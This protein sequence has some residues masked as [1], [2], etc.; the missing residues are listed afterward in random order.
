MYGEIQLYINKFIFDF[1]GYKLVYIKKFAGLINTF[2]HITFFFLCFRFFNSISYSFVLTII[3][4]LLENYNDPNYFDS[5]NS[6]LVLFFT[7]FSYLI[8]DLFYNSGK[9]IY[10]V[11]LAFIIFLMTIT[12]VNYGIYMLFGYFLVLIAKNFNI[13]EIKKI[14]ILLLNNELR[15]YFASFIVIFGIYFYY[16]FSLNSLSDWLKN[17]LV[18]P[19]Y[20]AS[21]SRGL[22]G[23]FLELFPIPF[24]ARHNPLYN[25]IYF[26]AAFSYFIYLLKYLHIYIKN[27]KINDTHKKFFLYSI[28]AFF[29][30]LN[31]NPIIDTWHF[32]WS[33]PL[34]LIFNFKLI[35]DLTSIF[36]RNKVQIIS[37]LVLLIYFFPALYWLSHRTITNKISQEYIIADK[38]DFIAGMKLKNYEIEFFEMI[39]S[40]FSIK[41]I[42]DNE[43]IVDLTRYPKSFLLS[44]DEN[45]KSPKF[46]FDF[47]TIAAGSPL[48]YENYF[49][50][51]KDY[52]FL[53]SP[54]IISDHENL[55]FLNSKIISKNYSLI[56]HDFSKYYSK[57]PGNNF[58]IFHPNN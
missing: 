2:T 43:F 22:G 51:I 48:Y 6:H 26:F 12:K 45:K 40:I 38:P 17:T 16:L 29:L 9:K 21:E 24:V 53:N 13:N 39:D 52:I 18:N 10:L 4:I 30:H 25:Y 14:K 36:Y 49:E 7:T 32:Y 28:L 35:I 3:F 42:K 44:L 37:I 1:F 56:N 19:I 47:K 31:F 23:I 58:Y 55:E 11:L 34:L 57:K 27:Y 50:Y 15:I 41:Q 46:Y 5:S 54:I 20:V 33:S 8:F